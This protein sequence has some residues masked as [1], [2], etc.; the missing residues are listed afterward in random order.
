MDIGLLLLG[1][2]LAVYGAHLCGLYRL[3]PDVMKLTGY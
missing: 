3:F 1:I 2:G